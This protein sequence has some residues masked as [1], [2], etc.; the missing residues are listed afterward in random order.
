MKTRSYAKINLSL[1]VVNKREDGYHN[2]KTIMQKV[3]LYDEL[4]F[5]IIKSGF[6]LNSDLKVPV[7]DNLIYKSWK[8][9]CN[10][11]GRELP[12]EITL[13]KN[14]PMAAGLAGGTGNGAVTLKAL[15]KIYNLNLSL[16]D[17]K[18]MSLSLG[19]DF[20]YMLQGGTVLAEGIGEEFT[21]LAPFEGVSVLIV[22][23][24]Y[25][26]STKVVYENLKIDENRIDFK[27]IV[28]CME[29]KSILSLKSLLENKMQDYVFKVHPD[30]KIIVE[31]LSKL[32]A[33]SLMSG[34]GASVFGLFNNCE[35]MKYAHSI[36]AKRYK[37][38]FMTCTVGG[39]DEV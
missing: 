14:I 38:A 16:E 24:G 9:M 12:I 21:E 15:N 19:A 1:D 34:T 27:G 4:E 31:E 18:E 39:Y 37:Y 28:N 6:V 35:D 32:G 33:V 13:K 11:V 2:I 25:E 23:P 22:N 7:E 10:F 20:P 5:N 8:V 36:L 29:N 3:S 17:L 26:I 30:I